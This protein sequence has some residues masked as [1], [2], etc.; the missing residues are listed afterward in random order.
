MPKQQRE[1]SRDRAVGQPT[2]R[3]VRDT[4]EA[5]STGAPHPGPAY[6]APE[7]DAASA[8]PLSEKGQ[9]REKR[10]RRKRGV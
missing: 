1:R 7:A 6:G 2:D 8:G 10:F 5:G 9:K 3:T 4:S